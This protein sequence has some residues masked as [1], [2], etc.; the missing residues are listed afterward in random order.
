MHGGKLEELLATLLNKKRLELYF[1]YDA[2]LEEKEL[3]TYRNWIKR[4]GNKE[5]LAYILG[6][7][8][9]LNLQLK[10]TPETLIP[11]Q[12]TE[13]LA[14]LI[15]KALPPTP[16]TIWDLCTGS[17]CLGLSLKDQRPDCSV[18]LSD[19]SREALAV[20]RDNALR[21]ELAVE[22]V[23]GDLLAPFKG[24]TCDVVVC[25]PPYVTV[26]AYEELEDEVRLFEPKRAL[27]G[28]VDFY[29]RLSH[30]LPTYLKPQAQIFFEIGEDQG[31]VLHQIFDQSHWK[32]K[33]CEKDWAG[34]DRFFFLEYHPETE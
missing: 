23:H 15:G 29:Q 10:V 6:E 28:G 30:D 32:Q 3:E 26:E 19:I 33:R 22:M 8:E 18:T 27:V 4:K 7:V 25:N 5:P 2:P 17:G 31:E 9:F 14:S 13:I 21:N 1:D 24:K 20:A 34:R 11:R 16:L 12:E